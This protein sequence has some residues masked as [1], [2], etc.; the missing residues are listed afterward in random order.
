MKIIPIPAAHIESVYNVVMTEGKAEFVELG[1]AESG[2]LGLDYQGHTLGSLT[3]FEGDP[4]VVSC[5]P[6]QNGDMVYLVS[7]DADEE[8][9]RQLTQP[10]IF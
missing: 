9:I 3:A 8:T 2:P 5:G 1:D 7:E 6:D 10:E 4:E